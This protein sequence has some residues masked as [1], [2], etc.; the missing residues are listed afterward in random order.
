[1]SQDNR[2]DRIPI[3]GQDHKTNKSSDEPSASLIILYDKMKV[4]FE[5]LRSQAS[6]TKDED[7]WSYTSKDFKQEITS[8]EKD[9]DTYCGWRGSLNLTEHKS[10]K[11]KRVGVCGLDRTAR[12]KSSRNVLNHLIRNGE[13]E[14]VFFAEKVIQDKGEQ[15]LLIRPAL[16][17]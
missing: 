9:L 1:M 2:R 3:K 10:N 11:S 17:T 12:S 15:S 16:I 6:V 7:Q 14:I 13:F 8:F 4:A 5:R